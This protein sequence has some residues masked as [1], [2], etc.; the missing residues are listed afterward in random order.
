MDLPQSFLPSEFFAYFIG[1]TN[2]CQKRYIFFKHS[3]NIMFW[4]ALIFDFFSGKKEERN[5]ENGVLNGQAI[6]FGTDGDKFEFTYVDGVIQGKYYKELLWYL[7]ILK[8]SWN[9]RP[10]CLFCCKW[11][12][13]RKNLCRQYSTWLVFQIFREIKGEITI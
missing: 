13:R 4:A 2:I 3:W 10:S 11:S 8:N 9:S 7:C 6:I 12:F 5:Y 1:G